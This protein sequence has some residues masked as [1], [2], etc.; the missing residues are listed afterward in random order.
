MSTEKRLDEQALM[1]KALVEIRELRA[2]LDR[3]EPAR[4]EPVAVIGMGCRLPG[5]GS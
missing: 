5:S 3:P 4:S 1:R 2:R